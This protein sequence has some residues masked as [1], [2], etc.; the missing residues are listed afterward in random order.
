MKLLVVLPLFGVAAPLLGVALKGRERMQRC[1][2]AVMCFMTINGLLGPG[3]WGLTL[4]SVETYRGHT[5][6]FHF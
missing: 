1:V 3:N 2:F 5:K 4:M 6:G